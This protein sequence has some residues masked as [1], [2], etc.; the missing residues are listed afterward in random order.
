MAYT[1]RKQHLDQW[2]KARN[3]TALLM[4]EQRDRIHRT[5]PS[6]WLENISSTSG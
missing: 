2:E 4:Q 6:K 5:D 1:D 3:S